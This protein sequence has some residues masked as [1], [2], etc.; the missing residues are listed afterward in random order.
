MTDPSKERIA[1]VGG[2][3]QIHTVASDGTSH[4][5]LTLSLGANPLLTWGQP[6][7][8]ETAHTWPTWSPD[9]QRLICFELP[10]GDDVSG[11]VRVQ[12]V[13]ADG[14]RQIEML[15]IS[16]RLPIYAAW[17][18][19]G[20]GAAILLQDEEQLVLGWARPDE[21]GRLR[22]LEEG[23]PLFFSW[24]PSE[25]RVLIHVGESSGGRTPGR[26][27]VRDVGGQL[28]DELL[29]QRPGNYCVPILVGDRIV[30]VDTTTPDNPGAVNRL[31]NTGLDGSDEK[32]LLEFSGLG[33]L[34]SVP[35][36]DAVVF[37]A[38]PNGEGTPYRGATLIPLDGG[39][40]NRLMEE[41]CLAFFW[42]VAAGALIYARVLKEENCVTWNRVVPGGAPEEVARFWPSRE[43][44]FYLH[45]FDQ[46]AQSHSLLSPDG[47][48]LVFCGRLLDGD[49][50]PPE[51]P[52]PAWSVS[53]TGI[54]ENGE[55]T[56][57]VL[58]ADLTKTPVGPV[59]VRAIASGSFACFSPVSG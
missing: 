49:D 27:I 13:E 55:E 32:N 52:G 5:Q 41:D 22:I 28:P 42:S 24:H 53:T 19:D 25:G 30:Q 7:L 34:S 15:S 36:R 59:A 44:L 14:L 4:T 40:L 51:H 1:Y 21:P 3:N 43:M 23:A 10:D 47:G 17:N 9:G 6:A 38:A 50:E 45:F 18:P 54:E 48:R 56:S 57:R 58:V 46:F 35:G 29:P 37:S 20:E 8:E 2:D 12:V 39:P 31:L 33:A 11:P 26:L 16:G